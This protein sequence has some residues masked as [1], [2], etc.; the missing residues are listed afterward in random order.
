MHDRGAGGLDRKNKTVRRYVDAAVAVGLS[1]VGG[2]EQPTDELVG[3]AV[4]E[5]VRPGP[6]IGTRHFGTAC[7]AIVRSRESAPLVTAQACCDRRRG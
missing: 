6:P 3:A 5:E 7:G 2:E 4:V 1:R